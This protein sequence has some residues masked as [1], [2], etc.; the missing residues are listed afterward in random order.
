LTPEAAAVLEALST[1]LKRIDR[2]TQICAHRPPRGAQDGMQLQWRAFRR[3][4]RH[5]SRRPA[6][7]VARLLTPWAPHRAV[8]IRNRRCICR[9]HHRSSPWVMQDTRLERLPLPRR[10]CRCYVIACSLQTNVK[11]C[12]A[13][14]ADAAA[15]SHGGGSDGNMLLMRA[16]RAHCRDTWC[17]WVGCSAMANTFDRGG[18]GAVFHK[19]LRGSLE[20]MSHSVEP[21][22]WTGLRTAAQPQKEDGQ[23]VRPHRCTPTA[24]LHH[25][26]CCSLPSAPIPE[27]LASLDPRLS[28]SRSSQS[29]LVRNGC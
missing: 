2:D 8:A 19:A 4:Q 27:V 12:A 28:S 13:R 1:H 18:T 21:E 26:C 11:P 29:R 20:D 22:R 3:D 14:E 17:A 6:R 16:R 24:P 5:T 25:V 9:E 7:R 15:P 10:D 23:S